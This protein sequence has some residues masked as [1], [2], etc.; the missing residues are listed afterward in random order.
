MIENI[1]SKLQKLL[2][3]EIDYGRYYGGWITWKDISPILTM[4]YLLENESI[5][6][7]IEAL[8]LGRE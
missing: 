1:S 5:G 8:V 3:P 4:D 2:L 7:L 6:N